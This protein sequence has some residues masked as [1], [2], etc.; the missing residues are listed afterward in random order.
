MIVYIRV[1]NNWIVLKEFFFITEH[2]HVVSVGKQL[3]SRYFTI[4]LNESKSHSV[5]T[6]RYFRLHIEFNCSFFP[7][8]IEIHFLSSQITILLSSI[9]LLTMQGIKNTIILQ[10]L[11]FNSML[12]LSAVF[13]DCSNL[14]FKNKLKRCIESL[15]IHILNRDFFY[16]SQ[17]KYRV[18]SGIR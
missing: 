3:W 7:W 10:L 12:V 15:Y 8:D 11:A 1:I 2:L 6:R 5:N 13:D 14:F 17:V 18:Q 16:S 9:L 4:F